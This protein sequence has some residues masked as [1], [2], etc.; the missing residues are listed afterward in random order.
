VDDPAL[1]NGVRA[2]SNLTADYMM[3]AQRKE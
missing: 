1:I 2:L 3:M